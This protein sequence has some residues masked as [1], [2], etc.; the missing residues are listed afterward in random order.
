MELHQNKI[1]LYM[2]RS[3]SNEAT[4][5][6]IEELM[7]LLSEDAALQ[8]QYDLMKRLW[9]ANSYTDDSTDEKGISRIISRAA[10]E[11]VKEMQPKIGTAGRIKKIFYIS[12]A[13][14]LLVSV[15]FWFLLGQVKGNS[16]V[17]NYKPD[18]V[19]T[20]K[21]TRT[22]TLL[23]DGSSV[24]LN[25]GSKISYV[26]DFSG[27]TRE[28]TLEG[29]AF[30]DIAKQP[31]RPFIVHVSGYDIKVLGTAFNVKSYPED[32]T[33]ETT[34]L[35]GLVQLTKEGDGKQPPIYIHPNQKIIVEKPEISKNVQ[36][37]SLPRQVAIKEYEI[38]NIDSAEADKVP[39]TAWV[40]NRLDFKGES[41]DELAR[42]MERWYNISIVFED[43]KAKQLKFT[44]SFQDE[45]IEQAF[46]ALDAAKPFDYSVQGNK[47]YVGTKN[48]N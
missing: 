45:T 44:G 43:E 31:N 47:V 40:Y 15:T 33:V 8:Q 12:T 38:I 22:K 2:S 46:E 39:E 21:G 3:L 9:N 18:D 5:A 16:V 6:E 14:V 25:A 23:P 7:Q 34:L 26:N 48:D 36:D 35:R 32:K 4:T 28:I 1:W 37:V 19:L 29:E 11:T 20:Q 27:K 10:E 13:A 30:F 41:F 24:W 42:K 17:V